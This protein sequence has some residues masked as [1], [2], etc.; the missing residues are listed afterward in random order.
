MD[1]TAEVVWKGSA[2]PFQAG[3]PGLIGERADPDPDRADRRLHRPGH[4]LRQPGAPDHHSVDAPSAGVGA[5]VALL[6]T[7][8]E[9]TIIALIGIILLIGIVKK[10]ASM[11]IGFALEAERKEGKSPLDAVREA[12]L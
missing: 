4:P 5:L 8:S 9:L 3:L 11:M 2:G 7:N 10:N 1:P 6:L 12:C